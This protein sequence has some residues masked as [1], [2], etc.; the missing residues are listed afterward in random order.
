MDLSGTASEEAFER[1]Q[2]WDVPTPV[3]EMTEHRIYWKVCSHGQACTR[4]KPPVQAPHG[5]RYGANMKAWAVYLQPGQLLPEDRLAELFQD[6]FGLKICPATLVPYGGRCWKVLLLA[7]QKQERR[8][9]L[10]R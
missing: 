5:V 8:L 3:V 9:P 2:V 7:G 6:M 10:P 4:A 1:C